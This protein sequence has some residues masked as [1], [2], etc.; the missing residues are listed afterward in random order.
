[1]FFVRRNCE[2]KKKKQ[3]EEEV[4]SVNGGR[5]VDKRWSKREKG[6]NKEVRSKISAP[7][8]KTQPKI[9]APTFS[10]PKF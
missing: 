7:T 5:E 9:S 4:N 10:M 8:L 3:G 1:M 2:M 6:R